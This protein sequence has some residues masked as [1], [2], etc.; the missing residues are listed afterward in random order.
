[1]G[2]SL[3]ARPPD[4]SVGPCSSIL[5]RVTGSLL[6]QRAWRGCAVGAREL[7]AMIRAVGK[8]RNRNTLRLPI[9][10]D[11]VTRMGQ[12]PPGAHLAMIGA[13]RRAPARHPRAPTC[14]PLHRRFA[15]SQ[16]CVA[17]RHSQLPGRSTLHD[18]VGFRHRNEHCWR[19]FGRRV[20]S[21]APGWG[22]RRKCSA[23]ASHTEPFHL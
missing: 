21:L 18:R 9:G 22:I 12:F 11:R 3:G 5:L 6:P 20:R 19:G 4:P 16:R 2:I 17:V 7:G 14:P 23:V 15:I 10:H 8:T 1:M 13:D